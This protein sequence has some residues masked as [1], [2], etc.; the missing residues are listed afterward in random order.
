MYWLENIVYLCFFMACEM[1]LIPF[2]YFKNIPIIA[3]A[4]KGLFTTAFF[5]ILWI[6]TGPLVALFLAFR[7]VYY[8]WYL[9]TL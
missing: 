9:F 1:L 2:V 3:W 8:L 4:T 6:T 5:V 7:D